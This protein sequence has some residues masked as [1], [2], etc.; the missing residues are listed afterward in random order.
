MHS[1]R[2]L[3]I[4]SDKSGNG[5]DS[6]WYS[7]FD[8]LFQ[9]SDGLSWLTGEKQQYP[10]QNKGNMFHNILALQIKVKEIGGPHPWKG[11]Y[12]KQ[13]TK[14]SSKIIAGFPVIGIT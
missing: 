6:L 2:L 5:N 7:E 14:R 11:L 12:A 3:R 9:K 10:E 4:V 13:R 1:F 8:V